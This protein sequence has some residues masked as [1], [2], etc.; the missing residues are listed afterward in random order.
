M[1][2]K[3]IMGRA[4]ILTILFSGSFVINA[5]KI[6]HQFR[7][8]SL[9][10]VLEEVERQLQYSIIYK[11][12]EVNE[13]K[14]I[15]HEFKDSSIDEV[16]SS[17]LDSDLSYSIE[18]K[19]IVISQR[20]NEVNQQTKRISGVVLDPQNESVIGA[21]IM[22][23]G[24][25]HGTITDINGNFMLDVP[26]NGIIQISYIGYESQEIPVKG[27]T[28]FNITLT[29]SS[30]NLDEVVVIGY[31]SRTKKDLTG[32]VAQISS[33]E[34]SNNKT[35]SPEFAMQGKMAGVFVSNP[36]SS[37]T[38]RP[39]I[40]IRGVST[41]GYN[42]PLYV[43]D[44][45]PLTEGGASSSD[46][47]LQTLRGGI[48]IFN[49]INPN[50]IESISVLKDASATAI[51][52]V[53]AS[54]GVILITTKRGSEGRTNVD[55]S[56]SYGIQNIFKRYDTVSMQEYINMSLEAIDANPAYV[57][58]QYYPFFDKNSSQYLGNSPDYRDDWMDAMLQE[59]AAIQDYNISV[60]GG[61][62][63]TNYALGAGYAKQDEAIYK[64]SFDRFSFFLNSDHKLGN[65]LKLGES[66]R[67]AYSRTDSETQPSFTG[68]S[69][70]MPWQP[71][72]D[73]N[74][75]NGLASTARTVDGK[76]LPYGYGQATINNFLGQAE[77]Q[78][79]KTDLLRNI[80]TFYAELTPFKG[81]RV[82]G[83]FSFDYYTQKADGYVEPER[84]LYEIG[85]GVLYTGEGN[86]YNLRETENVNFVKE[87][88]IGYN[89]TFGEHTVD[90][91]LNAMDQD[92]K[93][94]V[95]SISVEKNS[96]IPNWEQHY[97]NE[98][99]DAANKNAFYERYYSGL[100]GYM[101]RLSY[102]FASKYYFDVTVRRDGTS[103]FGPGYKWG[104]FP[105]FAGAWR[106]SSEKF[107]EEINWLDD[108][109]L[110]GGWGKSG[111]Q[112]TRDYAYLS[113]LNVNPK[114]AFG[115][116]GDGSGTIYQAAAL[117]DFPIKDMSWETVTTLS[118][119]FDLTALNN[120]FSFTG[121]YYNRKTDGIL[122]QIS[123][124]LVVGALSKPVINLA[125]V[126]NKGIEL[127]TSFNDKI[128]DIGFNVSANLT[129]VKNRVSNLYRG[130]PSTTGNLRIEDGYSM[131]YIYGLKT[132]GIFQTE[133]E[134][135]DW[136]AKNNDIGYSSQKA[137]GDVRY[138]DLYGAPTDSNPDGALKNYSPDGKIDDYD[139]TYLGKTI[140]GYYY[141]INLG[142]DYKN[143][144]I[145]LGFRGVGDVQKVNSLGLLSIA[146]GGQNFLTD[147][148]DRWTT[149]NHSN[150]I[151]RA[152]QSDPS[153]NN[154]VS[155]RFVQDASFFRFQNF[156]IGYNFKSSVLSNL[157][158]R[159]LRCYFSG[160]NLF[161]ISSY[162]DLDPENIT[163][164]TTFTFGA[165][166][167]F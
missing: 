66:F 130:N 21:S 159:K 150:K 90:L 13:N 142:A 41:L 122:Q 10:E 86:R 131:N 104:T 93:W 75:T 83:T 15:T 107:M 63:A 51:Y 152:I 111:N 5:Q 82:K 24:T 4:L 84:G 46:A 18:G 39:E 19:M 94:R 27:K 72:Y 47:R 71:L 118:L 7:Q 43:I 163:T 54:N 136:V 36:G 58:D 103:K 37:P 145:T 92:I 112:E 110:R 78:V 157:G 165:N 22:I 155:D 105:A 53:R 164:P 144:D 34:I 32:A 162:N 135:A 154:R 140:P 70:M 114:A 11:K 74:Q 38:A 158:I 85:K 30:K 138:V 125:E 117:G 133:Q 120:R 97:I 98:G 62:R 50:D 88:L 8:A 28:S 35:M 121:E 33:D 9:K 73:S 17:I 49:L 167:S 81:F 2:Y 108:L 14:K 89:N 126:S 6:T 48:N 12:N 76:L 42:D 139:K 59:N 146:G 67:F 25:N 102:N 166:L 128:G 147:Y 29:E 55:F 52:G 134:V 113:L 109:K 40:R 61:N 60:S 79:A 156:Q 26:E 100:I 153:G 161:V 69:F 57:K 149:E 160:T 123:L 151:P 20:L 119:G 3:K 137:P 132:D 115:D 91:V 116:N 96:P 44:G 16:L 23:K 77:H 64:S 129:T 101:G 31:G 1:M 87:L 68:V 80:G 127:Q 95:K 143:W 99:W 141:G 65:W 56:M 45:I 124:P 148:R 106:I